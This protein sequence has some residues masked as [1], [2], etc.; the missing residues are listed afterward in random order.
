LGYRD[1]HVKPDL[2]LIH[3]IDFHAL[4]LARIGSHSKVFN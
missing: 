1:C 4:K 3:K 2:V